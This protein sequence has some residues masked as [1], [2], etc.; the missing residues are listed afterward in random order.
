MRVTKRDWGSLYETDVLIL[1]TG[2]SG[3]GAAL[4]AADVTLQ[5]LFAPPSETNFGGGLL[6]GTQSACKAACDAFAAAVQAVA[7][8]PIDTGGMTH[9]IG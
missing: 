6:T 9:G 1:G 2:A 7:A 5:S 3:M 8:R 4:K